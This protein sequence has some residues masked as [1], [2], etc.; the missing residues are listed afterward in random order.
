MTFV[1][2]DSKGGI[3]LVPVARLM[4]TNGLVVDIILACCYLVNGSDKTTPHQDIGNIPL[5]PFNC[6]NFVVNKL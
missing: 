1:V 4:N 6:T 3:F 2:L 5:D